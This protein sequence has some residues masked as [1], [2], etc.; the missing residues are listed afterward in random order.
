MS[1]VMYG[2]FVFIENI[3]F[4]AGRHRAKLARDKSAIF[5]SCKARFRRNSSAISR[6]RNAV[7]AE[8]ALA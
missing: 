8:K 4:L 7:R 1:T 3:Y 2:N 5:S 6:K